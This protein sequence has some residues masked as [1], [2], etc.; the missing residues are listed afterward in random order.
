MSSKNYIE[1]II[2]MIKNINDNERLKRIYKLTLYLYKKN[3]SSFYWLEF[4]FS[5]SLSIIFSSVFNSFS[6]NL[7]SVLNKFL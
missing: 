3:K 7:A 5:K 1:A 2:K 6:S 4:L